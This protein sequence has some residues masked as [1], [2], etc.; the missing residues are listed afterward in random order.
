MKT[1]FTEGPWKVYAYDSGDGP[2]DIYVGAHDKK[3]PAHAV[4]GVFA[5][6]N[7]AVEDFKQGIANARLKSAAPEM[8]EAL[9]EAQ[10]ELES[11]NDNL[12]LQLNR[13]ISEIAKLNEKYRWRKQANEKAPKDVWV[14]YGDTSQ[15]GVFM[16]LGQTK[17][18]HL[19]EEFY[20]RPIIAPR[21]EQQMTLV[22]LQ[23]KLGEQIKLISDSKTPPEERCEAAEYA[24]TICGL[25]KQMINNADVILRTDKLVSTGMIKNGAIK[26]LVGGYDDAEAKK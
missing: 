24:K 2:F 17:G 26:P 5:G 19:P 18:A 21:E 15:D 13:K 4:A 3:N 8:Y 11:S 14:E 7:K 16:V 23:E 22:E 1:E 6:I 20:W 10:T 9:I 12:R 25:A